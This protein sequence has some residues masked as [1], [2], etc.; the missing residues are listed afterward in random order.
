MREVDAGPGKV[1]LLELAWTFNHIALASFGGG[2][3]A[4]SREVLVV[5]KQWMGEEEFLSAMTM[6]RIFPGAKSSQ[7]GSVRRRE[8]AGLARRGRR[9][10]RALPAA[11]DHRLGN[12]LLLLPLQGGARGQGRPPWC[13]GSRRRAD[14]GHGDPDGPQMPDGRG[15]GPVVPHRVRVER[16]A[17]VA[18]AIG[19]SHRRAAE[20]GLVL[21]EKPCGMSTYLS[22][23]A[24]FATLSLLSIGGGNAVL[25]EM[26]MQAVKSHHWMT[27]SQ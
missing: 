18:A 5:E 7:H 23:A 3:S 6:C 8:N 15:P 1:S 14:V 2:L 21:A 22:L 27:D 19:A 10:V 25:P 11:G 13:V 12:G 26:H 20:S 9:A 16:P 4:W 17:A 24:L